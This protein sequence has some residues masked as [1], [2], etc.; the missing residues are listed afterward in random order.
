M[1]CIVSIPFGTNYIVL[2]TT[3]YKLGRSSSIWTKLRGG[4]LFYDRE[5]DDASCR[6]IFWA[7][8]KGHV[9]TTCRPQAAASCT[10]SI[11]R[12]LCQTKRHQMTPNQITRHYLTLST[13]LKDTKCHRRT[14]IDTKPDTE[15]P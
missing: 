11:C 9:G 3:C 2:H 15:G 7:S 1:N 10:T 14:I 5:R 8:I 12:L 6:N 4:I 13:S